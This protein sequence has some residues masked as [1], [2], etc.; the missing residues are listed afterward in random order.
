MSKMNQDELDSLKNEEFA[1]P[2][3][4]KE[5]ISNASHIRNAIARFNQVE[6]VTDEERDQ[7]WARIKRAAAKFHVEMHES[8]WRELHNSGKKRS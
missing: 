1:F 3:E 8:S 2:K 4:R 6:G 7:A 5:P